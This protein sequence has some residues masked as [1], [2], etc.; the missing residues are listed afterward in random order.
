MEVTC[1]L[2][3]LLR[4]INEAKKMISRA[5][6]NTAKELIME[7]STWILSKK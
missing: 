6:P 5:I 3:I 4:G 2:L 7:N 1:S